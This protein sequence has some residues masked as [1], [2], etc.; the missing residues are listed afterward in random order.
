MSHRPVIGLA[1]A[2]ALPACGPSDSKSAAP[3][4]QLAADL[5]AMLDSALGATPG[6]PGAM[7]RVEAPSLG[8]VWTRAVGW[9]DRTRRDSLRVEQPLRI[10]SNTKTYVAAA[11]LR[12]VETGKLGLDQPIA[13]HLLRGSISALETDSYRP[14][15]ITV[16]MLLQHTSGIADYATT[17]VGSSAMALYGPFF[18][19]IIADPT[20][21]WTRAEQLALAISAGEPYGKPGETYHYSDTGYNLLGEIIETVTNKPMHM[22]VR[23]LLGFDRLG[24]TRTWFETLDSIPAGSLPRVHQYLDSLDTNEFDGSIDLYGGGG[25]MSNLEDLAR[26]YR[27]LLRG[28]VFSNRATLD[29]MLVMSPQ[30]LREGGGYGMGIGRATYDDVLCFGHGGF[31]GTAARHCP[32]LDLTVTAAVNTTTARAALAAIVQGAIGRTAAA[33]AARP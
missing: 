4:T 24:L 10:A 15:L 7:L 14:D 2:L 12:L 17:G 3:T 33:I 22:A 9:S 28:S 23:E 29:S 31:W 32:A 20:H 5:S 13:P 26:F 6:L 8:F 25:L 19:R 1:L 11:T 16:R 27:A 30:S 18:D 21:R